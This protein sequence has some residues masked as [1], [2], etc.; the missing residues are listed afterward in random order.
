MGL[1]SCAC[2]SILYVRLLL[3]YKMSAKVGAPDMLAWLEPGDPQE[4]GKLHELQ[5][6]R[7]YLKVL[8]CA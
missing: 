6:Y 7:E 3:C 5:G 4:K 1:G 8:L 2:L